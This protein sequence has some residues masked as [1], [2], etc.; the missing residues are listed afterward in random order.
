MKLLARSI[1]MIALLTPPALSQTFPSYYSTADLSL[2]SPGA[3]KF[4]L[5]GYDN[6]ALLTYVHQPDF[7]FLWTDATGKWNDFNR[8]G[9]FTASPNFGFGV[10][11]TKV[12]SASVT[13]YRLSL[14]FGDKTLGFGLAYGFSGGDKAAFDRSNVWTVGALV[15]PDP[16]VSVGLVGSATSSGGRTE[17]AIDLG[18]R[19]LGNEWL[20]IFSDYAIQ[21]G[22]ALKNGSWS[23]GAAIEALPGI[24]VTGRYF[25]THAFAVGLSFS[26]GNAGFSGQSTF[27]KDAKH[28]FNTYAI[29][30]GAYD[31]TVLS[32]LLRNSKYVEMDLLGGMKYQR[33]MLFD[34][35]NT[36][37]NTL[38]AIAAAKNDETVSG[39]AI[40]TSGMHVNRE[41]LWELREQLKD[42]KSAGKKVVVFIDR[43]SMEEYRFATVAD[44]VV[45]DPMGM[46][47]LPGYIMGNTFLKGTLEKLGI[48]Y[49]EWRFFKYK[50]ANEY[51]SRDKMSDAEREQRQKYIDDLYAFTKSDVCQGRNLSPEQ[52]DQTIN[53]EVIYLP[54]EAVEKGLVDTLGRW[55]DVK[56][57]IERLEGS[58]KE[59]MGSGSLA[60]FNLPPDNRWGEPPRI[61][62]I[63]ALGVC[64]MDAG[65]KARDLVKD[66]EAAG[67]DP[68]IKAIILRVDSP[69]GDGMASDYVAEAMK[70]AKKNKPVIVSQGYVAGSGGYWLS[71]YADTIV[72]T[73]GTITGSIGVASGWMYNKELKEKLGM[74][75]DHVQMGKHADLGFGFRLP[76]LG[77]GIPDRTLTDVELA[78]AER[79]IKSFY[80]DFVKKVAEG[81]KTSPEKIEPIAQGRF[82]SGSEAKSLGLIDVLGGL[83]DAM[84]IA[85][86]KARIEA[87][88]EVTIV[89]MPKPGLLNFRS[90]MPCPFGVEQT[91][92]NDPM[93]EHLKFRLEHNGQPMPLMPLEEIELDVPRE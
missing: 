76:L 58:K 91:V 79:T 40:N 60:K 5:Y 34:K 31:R 50:S 9:L 53:D 43:P 68:R 63:Y 25:N 2:T 87:N 8:W 38:A 48:G 7:Q 41:M 84:R 49:D 26:L 35:S 15:R 62:V 27:D 72:S 90:F 36:L 37:R 52:F 16:H 78:A 14:G 44:K 57:M 22:Q 56:T 33:F 73:P 12:A 93:V 51:L 83:E 59:M 4:G 19:P 77:V 86:Q 61:A 54:Q 70:K 88:E 13:D 75:T 92:A 89:E 21:D 29:R 18:L 71:M 30:L 65:I 28:S 55:G 64:A 1:L 66:V 11:K 20:T 46:I 6:P 24:R 32:R 42:F 3:L 39:I 47:L 69:G 74:S 45:L 10:V 82:Y 80:N 67:D 23:Y 81:R 85:K 17:A